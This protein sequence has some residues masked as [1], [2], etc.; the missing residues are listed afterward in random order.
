ME[1]D[2]LLLS[3]VQRAQIYRDRAAHL[4]QLASEIADHDVKRTLLAIAHGWL[5][6]AVLCERS[7][8]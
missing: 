4:G 3:T 6:L 8:S 5:D 7:T 1:E 2:P